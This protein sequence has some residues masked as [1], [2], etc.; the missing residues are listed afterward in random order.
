MICTALH[1]PIKSGT[2]PLGADSHAAPAQPWAFT[3]A[4]HT[5]ALATMVAAFVLVPSSVN[6]VFAIRS[7]RGVAYLPCQPGSQPV[8]VLGL[9]QTLPC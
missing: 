6:A 5:N 3:A 8:Q 4:V 2:R 9:V 1:R 7:T